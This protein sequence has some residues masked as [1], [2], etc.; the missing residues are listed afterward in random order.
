MTLPSLPS[1][2]DGLTVLRQV[3]EA[4][5][6]E[7]D[8]E[9]FFRKAAGAAARLV[10]ADA[11]ALLL[12]NADGLLE[13]QFF[14]GVPHGYGERFRG[15]TFDRRRGVAGQALAEQRPVFVPDYP[16]YPHA[17]AEFVA[18]GL[19][20][21]L[22]LPLQSAGEAVGVLVMSWFRNAVHEP[23]AERLALLATIGAQLGVALQRRRLEQQLEY[24]ASHDE[25]T[26][27]PNRSHFLCRLTQ[28]LANGK[29][30]GRRYALMVIDLDGFKAVNDGAGHAAGD[31]LLREVGQKLREVV[32]TGDVVGRLGG[33][34]FVLLM[35]YRQWPEE[36]TTLAARLLERLSLQVAVAGGSVAVSPSIGIAV[37]PED[38]SDADTLLANADLAMYEAKRQRGGRQLCFF[39]Q[40]IAHAVR[41]RERLLNEVAQAL[42]SGEFVL[43]YQPIVDLPSGRTVAVEA[44]LRWIRPDGSLR[45]PS[46]FIPEVERH[47]PRLMQDIGRFVLESAVRQAET[48]F[49]A[50]FSLTVAVN[51][52]ARELLEEGFLPTLAEL[53]GRHPDLP[54]ER[55]M[56]EITETAALEKLAHARSIMNA[57]RGLGV[58]FAIDDFGTGYASLTNLRELP[59]DRVKIDR[60]FVAGLPAAQ[61]DRA[62]VQAILRVAQVFGVD[63]VAEGVETPTQA[64]ALQALGCRLMQGY[65]LAHPLPAAQIT[66]WLRDAK[67]AALPLT[68]AGPPLSPSRILE[69]RL[70]SKS[71]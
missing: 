4:L 33:D 53:L 54:R 56:L 59:V 31:R 51:V 36:P 64:R 65:G 35:E 17:I 21:S 61:G 24:R 66:D 46:A 13:Y 49:R 44:L 19:R 18:S 11:A 28:S 8:F 62:V 3:I 68:C 45:L 40:A 38:G 32:R 55:L 63:V 22:A 25:L 15:F 12:L 14:L 43:H 7:M 50:G 52:S 67:P 2:S 69:H 6:L 10:G 58:R 41:Q 70:T 20:A 27:L 5:S 9:A 71:D 39:N 47:N 34:E 60:S 26:G 16:S 30:Y 29:R 42:G 1:P 48:W 23:D 37:F 57:C